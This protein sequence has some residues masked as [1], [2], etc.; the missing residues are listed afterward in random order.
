M[1]INLFMRCSSE[2]KMSAVKQ[3][4]ALFRNS[5]AKRPKDDNGPRVFL[6]NDFRQIVFHVNVRVYN[7]LTCAFSSM[8]NKTNVAE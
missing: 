3:L 2:E 7:K 1:C 4:Y 8:S 5:D 6:L